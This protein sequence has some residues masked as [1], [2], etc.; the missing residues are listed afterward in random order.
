MTPVSTTDRFG[1]PLG[2]AEAAVPLHPLAAANQLLAGETVHQFIAESGAATLLAAS[3]V[4]GA[5]GPSTGPTPESLGARIDAVDLAAPLGGTNAAL[6][7]AADLYLKDAVYFHHPRYQAHLNCPVLI[8]AVAA[9]AL[10][11]SVNS[12]MDTWDQSAGA[13]LIERRLTRWTAA[14]LIGL[15][16]DADGVF[17]SGGTQSNLQAMLIARNHAV[18]TRTGSLPERLAGLRIY[19]SADSHFSIAKAATL[20]GMGEDAVVAVPTDR[21]HRMDAHA[22][23]AAIEADTAAGLTPMAVVATAGTTDFGAI[24]PLAAC[25]ALAAEHGAWFHV[26]AAYGCGLLVSRHRDCLAG[27]EAADSVTVDFHK[28]FFQPIG[29]SALILADD[30]HFGHIT[31]Y[32]DYLNPAGEAGTVPNQVD[33]SLQTTRRFDA[34]KLWVSLRSM[35]TDAIGALF[36]ELI[37]LAATAASLVAA[38]PDLELAADVQLSTV[39]FRYLPAAHDGAAPLDPAAVNALQDS[40]RAALYSSGEAMVA[41]TTVDG[42]RHLKLTLL[43]PRATLADLDAVLAAVVVAGDRLSREATR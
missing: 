32:A 41:A 25:S 1:V 17:T 7:E 26:D 37:D 19:T 21:A 27:I 5:R 36:D 8:P 6:T 20:L 43:N 39:V 31:H 28:S 34:L 9:E 11:T 35:G 14:D 24:D 40:I 13:T 2:T 16:A 23:R 42:A 18:A 15:G 12:S 3:A 4:A 33:K 30:A 10:V 38:H 22:L 29:S